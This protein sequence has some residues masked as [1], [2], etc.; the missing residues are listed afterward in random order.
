MLFR[1]KILSDNYSLKNEKLEERKKFI[2]WKLFVIPISF[3]AILFSLELFIEAKWG[4]PEGW[5]I[6]ILEILLSIEIVYYIFYLIKFYFLNKALSDFLDEVQSKLSEKKNLLSKFVELKNKFHFN[7]FSFENDLISYYM[8]DDIIKKAKLNQ[9]N[10]E[11]FKILISNKKQEFQQEKIN[12]LF[13]ESPFEF[14]IITKEEIE[15]IYSLSAN[16][17]IVNRIEGD[18][19]FSKCYRD[20]IDTN[21]LDSIL[22]P[23]EI[24]ANDIYERKVETESLKTILFNESPNFSKNINTTAKFTQIIETSR[25]LLRTSND[26][27]ISSPDIPYTQNII[28][29]KYDRA[30]ENY[31]SSIKFGDIKV[32]DNN[33]NSLGIISIKSNLPAFLIYDVIANEEI[34]RKSTRLNSSHEWISRMP[35]SA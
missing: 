24:Q 9:E 25:P 11:N 28:V 30:F 27:P 15:K 4:L 1:S 6:D 19:N 20:F 8:V 33:K 5:F 34:D 21:T 10:I 16:S 23:I 2:F 22:M 7:N 35:S 14:C 13:N 18:V 12:F 26:I 3:F 17:R 31:L 29:G 32:D